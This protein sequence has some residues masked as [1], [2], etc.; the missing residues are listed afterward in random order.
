MNFRAYE[1]ETNKFRILVP[2]GWLGGTTETSNIKSIT[3][4]YPKEPSTSNV[5]IAIT[6][7]V[8]IS[9]H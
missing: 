5:S 8:Q 1:D 2:E 4:F 9:P 3:A 6:V 7:S